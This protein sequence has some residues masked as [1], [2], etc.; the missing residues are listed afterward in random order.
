MDKALLELLE[1]KDLAYITVKELC[2]A[3]GVNRSTFYLHYETVADLLDECADYMTRQCFE[4]YSE[5]YAGVACRLATAERSEL[6]FISPAYLRP[7]FEFVR[8]NRALFR[9]VFAGRTALDTQ[10]TFGILFQ[11]VFS[12][13]LDRFCFAEADKPYI[14]AFYLAGLMA[15]VREWIQND[16]RTPLDKVI[17]LTMQCVLPDEIKP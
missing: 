14:L 9:A 11:N 3:A 6:V 17:E 10:K 5:E 8:E 13:V 12:P 15:I 2:R 7:Y 4:R 16:C 1:K